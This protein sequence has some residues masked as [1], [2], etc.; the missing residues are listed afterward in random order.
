MPFF[1]QMRFRRADGAYRWMKSI[2]LPRFDSRG[3]LA[4]Y[5]GSSFDIHDLKLAEGALR[6]A[7]RRKNEF[8]AML[9][10]EL[11]NPLAPIKNVVELLKAPHLDAAERAWAGDVLD[12]QVESM[13]RMIED[14]LDVSRITQGKVQLRLEPADLA[15]LLRRLVLLWQPRFAHR[16]QSLELDC[17]EGSSM[18]LVDVVRFEQLVGNLLGNA[19]KFTPNGGHVRLECESGDSDWITI[20]VRDDG[21]GI[22][23][24]EL[25]RIF[26]LFM[27]FERGSDRA[28]GGLGIGLTLVKRLV[29]LHGGTVEARSDGPGHG[30]EFS[31]R[32]PRLAGGIERQ[33]EEGA[34]VRKTAGRAVLPRRVLV[35][36][37]NVDGALSWAILLRIEGH[38][39]QVAHDA[40]RA[41]AI[42][43]GFRPE[44]A[45]VDIGLP[46]MDGVELGRRLRAADGDGLLLI[47]VSGYAADGDRQRTREAGFDHHFRKP[48]E[49]DVVLELLAKHRDEAT[50]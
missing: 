12:R 14:L 22:T 37:D 2:G 25:P 44:A 31:I 5:V 17:P 45:I 4:G 9:A 38:D 15:P 20:R 30:A 7:D 29:E 24:E 49:P 41:L 21:Q 8:L 19:M 46:G 42:A 47:A 43:E 18:A 33:E 50:S 3:Q 40:S 28:P 11:R 10:H 34:S 16:Q 23:A 32:L 27:Q 48:I 26:D 1:S 36:D 13:S 35:V 39:V 6:D